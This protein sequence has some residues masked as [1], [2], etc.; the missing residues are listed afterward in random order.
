MSI[1]IGTFAHLIAEDY[2]MVIFEY[3]NYNL[4]EESYRNAER[5]EDGI[6]AIEKSC[7]H[8]PEI[9]EKL[10]RMPSGR[11]KHIVKRIPTRTDYLTMI[12]EGKIRVENTSVCWKTFE[13]GIDVMVSHILFYLFNQ[14]QED[15][16][17]PQYIS[18]NY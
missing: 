17:I 13:D 2:E 3:G 9:H 18:L 7:F 6:L 1:G 14:Y 11:K 5:I 4:N 16:V 12:Q 8:E 10:K 15:G